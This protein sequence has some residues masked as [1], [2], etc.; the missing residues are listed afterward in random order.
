VVRSGIPL[1]H[2]A[3][4]LAPLLARTQRVERARSAPTSPFEQAYG[5][6][7]NFER[8]MRAEIDA[9]KLAGDD[10]TVVLAAVRRWHIDGVFGIWHREQV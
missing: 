10:M 7:E 5:S 9:G 2:E 4:E 1:L 3:V 8:E 6:L